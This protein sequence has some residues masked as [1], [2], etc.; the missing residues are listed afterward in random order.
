MLDRRGDH[1][2]ELLALVLGG[3]ERGVGRVPARRRRLVDRGSSRRHTPER[4][5]G[6][7]SL[8]LEGFGRVNACLEDGLARGAG[9]LLDGQ[10][11][12]RLGRIYEAFDL[13]SYGPI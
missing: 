13:Y 9:N 1:V 2:A 8:Q 3:A 7:E 12:P 5:S 4:R 10:L 6:D 11:D